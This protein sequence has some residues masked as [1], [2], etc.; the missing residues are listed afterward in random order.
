MKRKKQKPD[1]RLDWRDPEM[2][3]IDDGVV[4][5]PNQ[6]QHERNRNL[7]RSSIGPTSNKLMPEWKNDPTYDLRKK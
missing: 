6:F 4:K 2:P 1:T 5:T 3:V 7:I